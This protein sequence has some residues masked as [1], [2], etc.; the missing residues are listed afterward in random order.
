MIIFAGAFDG[1]EILSKKHVAEMEAV[2]ERWLRVRHKRD[3]DLP[4]LY[5]VYPLYF[6][7]GSGQQHFLLELSTEMRF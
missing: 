3:R 4:R 1:E 7:Y 5:T 2:G 6:F